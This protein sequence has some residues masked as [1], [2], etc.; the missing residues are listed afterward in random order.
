MSKAVG[1]EEVHVETV[2]KDDIAMNE[3]TES[4]AEPVPHVHAKTILLVLV[5]IPLLHYFVCFHIFST[6][7][8]V[9]LLMN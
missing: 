9:P 3:P 6:L 7:S 2:R 1:S 4:L 8:T 5:S